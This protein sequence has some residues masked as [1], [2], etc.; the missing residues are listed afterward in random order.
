MYIIEVAK[1]YLTEYQVSS[2]LNFFSG[3]LHV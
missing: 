1:F 3:S 2:Q